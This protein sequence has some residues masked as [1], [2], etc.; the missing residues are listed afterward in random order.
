MVVVRLFDGWIKL[1]K[2]HSLPQSSRNTPGIWACVL[3]ST[4]YH[5]PRFYA[6]INSNFSNDYDPSELT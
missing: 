1:A 2:V 4:M 6:T 5:V 3:A